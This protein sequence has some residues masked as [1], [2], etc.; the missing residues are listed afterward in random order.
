MADNYYDQ[1][2]QSASVRMLQQIRT[3][4]EC[5]AGDYA[6][7][8]SEGNADMAAYAQRE[9]NKLAA[10][11]NSLLGAAQQQAAQPQQQFTEVEKQI[12]REFPGIASD[13]KKFAEA[14]GASRNLQMR[15]YSRDSAE[16]DNA[17]RLAV[18]LVGTD[19]RDG[20]E[21]ASPQTAL[22]ATNNSR[23]AQRYG[24]VDWDTYERGYQ[25]L[26]QNKR[27]GLYEPK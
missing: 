19:G 5:E 11:Y 16:Y 13:P 15:G 3:Q 23:I 18:G 25:W 6:R 9:Y 10:E 14:I 4:A 7:Y 20:V 8:L 21:V 2:A 1:L 27:T 22:A 26:Q 17:M 12:L 24:G